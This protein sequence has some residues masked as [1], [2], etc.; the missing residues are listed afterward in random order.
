MGEY[1]VQRRRA[2]KF[3]WLMESETEV[4][5]LRIVHG[6]LKSS[7][8]DV[9]Q[10]FVLL[11]SSIWEAKQVADLNWELSVVTRSKDGNKVVELIESAVSTKTGITV[12]TEAGVIRGAKLLG[13]R[14]ETKRRRYTEE[15]LKTAAAKKMF[16]GVSV[17]VD[18]DKAGEVRP[19][20]DRLGK[21]ENVR[22]VPGE[23]LRGDIRY[24]P[25][26]PVAKQV[27]W[28]AANMPDA[29]C[30]SPVSV[31]VVR[32]ENGTE[33][34]HAIQKVKSVDIVSDGGTTKS[35]F[36]DAGDDGEHSED[37]IASVIESDLSTAAKV[38]RI[39][40]LR[41]SSERDTTKKKGRKRMR[42][43]DNDLSGLTLIELKESRPDLFEAMKAD[44]AAGDE[45]QTLK[46]SNEK[47]QKK[48]DEREAADKKA[49]RKGVVLKLLKESKVP[50][51]AITDV[52]VEQC[53][54]ET[55]D[56]KLKLLVEDR[57]KAA[58]SAPVKPQAK[59]Q[60][61]GEATGREDGKD[62]SMK[63]F[64]TAFKSM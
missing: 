33:V 58:G 55:D 21:T 23:G 19:V 59:E 54:A 15:A 17:N 50:E 6:P 63:D 12:D 34:V 29:L 64:A 57:R 9:V 39:K 40:E 3:K 56:T 35:L 53:V 46:E 61:M 47:L 26:H 27:A 37:T 49:E 36:E 25:D 52:F 32:M 18:H 7:G 14:A 4:S 20:R 1:R 5:G 2:G 62:V 13:M 38:R 16:E 45:V 41:E 43:D 22:Y 48:L 10:S 51:H 8:Q 30:M 24:N 11:A 31:G 44:L 60:T 28:F 42:D